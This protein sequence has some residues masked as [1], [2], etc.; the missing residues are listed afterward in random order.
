MKF[1][2]EFS[3]KK[4]FLRIIILS[5]TLLGTCYYISPYIALFEFQKALKNQDQTTYANYIN[6]PS[7]RKSL[8]PQIKLALTKAVTGDF[9]LKPYRTLS[10]IFIDPLVNG[11]VDATVTPRGLK[12][13]LENGTIL[14]DNKS[15]EKSNSKQKSSNQSDTS[16]SK[17]SKKEKNQIKLYYS[18]LNLFVLSSQKSST[19]TPIKAFWQR[20]GLFK[21]KLSSFIIPSD[22]L[23]LR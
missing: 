2:I 12:L 8:K 14:Q 13:L 11:I 23:N 10:L 4:Y 22:F 21:W 3:P 6:F 20:N 15:S 17:A 1:T 18:N 5:S 16:Q 19:E 7:V 9:N